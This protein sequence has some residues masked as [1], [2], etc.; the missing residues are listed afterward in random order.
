MESSDGPPAKKPKL[1]MTKTDESIE[2]K[3]IGKI[4]LHNSFNPSRKRVSDCSLPQSAVVK[5]AFKVHVGEGLHLLL[6]YFKIAFII[7]CMGLQLLYH[8]LSY[9]NFW[10]FSGL[11][12]LNVAMLEEPPLSRLLHS[13]DEVFLSSLKDR[14]VR[15]P[16]G[17]GIP[18]ISVTCKSIQKK[19]LFKVSNLTYLPPP[20]KSTI[21]WPAYI[22]IELRKD[23]K[24]YTD[25]K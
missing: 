19:E 20:P 1:S 5:N 24:I 16:M 4:P 23:T 8:L 9:P 17:P 22:S 7:L 13:I 10:L 11:M 2:Y 3:K 15:D 6:K 25:M 12:E 21:L 18:P 14:L